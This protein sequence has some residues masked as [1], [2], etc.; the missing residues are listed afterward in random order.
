MKKITFL[1]A[2]FLASYSLFAQTIVDTTAQNKNVILEEYTGI[3]CTY[4]PDGHKVANGIEAANPGDFFAINIHTGGYATPGAGEPDFRT[5]YGAGL[6]AQSG[7]TGYPMGSIN[8]H[9]FSG[10]ATAM[11]RGD[12][13]AATS[14]TVAQASYVNVAASASIN[15]K[16]RIMTVLVEGYFTGTTAPANMKL[17]VAVVQNNIVGPQTGGASNPD[18]SLPGGLYN[19]MH[20][21]RD[22]ITGQWGVS[23]DTTSQGTF[24]TRTFNYHI[25]N[26][27]NAGNVDL[28]NLEVIAY[29]A[30]GNQEII[31]GDVASMTVTFPAGVTAIDMGING[32]PT[33]APGVCDNSVTPKVW[34]RNHGTVA[35]DTFNVSYT[36]NGGTPVFQPI[37]TALNAGDSILVTFAVINITDKTNSLNFS[38]DFDNSTLLADTITVNNSAY[39]NDFYHLPSGTIGTIYTEDFEKYADLA[40]AVDSTLIINPDAAAAL[41]LSKSSVTGLTYDIGGFG[42]S[43]KSYF[44]NFY[45]IAPGK[46]VEMVFY[47]MDFSQDAGYGLIFN[48]AY[49]QYQSENDKLQVMISDDCGATWTTVF[50]KA[51]GALKTA[52]PNSAGN[53]FPETDQWAKNNID[54]SAYN[55]KNEVIVKFKCTSAYGNN[56]Y[57]DD[58]RVYNSTNVSI[59][60][61]ELNSSVTIYPNPATN[62]LNLNINLENSANVTYQIVNSLGQVVLDNNLGD[63]NNGQ[64]TQSVDVSDLAAGFYYVQLN[65]DGNII[66][67]KLTIK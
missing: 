21:F 62:Q 29:I 40:T 27:Y 41:I 11:S 51:G 38:V 58:I 9:V 52:P 24:F 8:R 7:L 35:A 2:M 10:S 48:H 55:G 60:A 47:K 36:F 61:P 46:V 53:F 39:L 13:A 6:A 67:K 16:T 20:V 3:H 19:H 34:V 63:L 30:E 1:F 17:N 56:L 54:L 28:R 37:T 31:T 5:A 44:V 64:H 18:Q 49:A 42:N 32:A 50:D 22:F 57:I 26:S 4:C 65:I 12:W 43:Q 15:M 59:E 23:I 14:T 33:T 66:S 45:N 25:P